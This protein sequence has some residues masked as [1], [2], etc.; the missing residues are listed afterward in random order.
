MRGTLILLCFVFGRV[1][2][3]PAYAGNTCRPLPYST[4]LRDHPRVC[5]EHASASSGLMAVMGS[6]PR[7]RGTPPHAHK[8]I[9]QR[10]IIP[11]YAGNTWYFPAGIYRIEDHPRVCGEH[12]ILGHSPA[13]VTGSSPRM[14]GTLRIAFAKLGKPRIIPAYAGNT[15]LGVMHKPKQAQ[16]SSPRMRG[17]QRHVKPAGQSRGIIPAYAGNTR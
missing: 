7:M 13:R 1:G 9:F 3:I 16:G 14:R 12:P 8:K 6:S 15:D 11:A 5:G 2:I 10:G 17:T 4:P